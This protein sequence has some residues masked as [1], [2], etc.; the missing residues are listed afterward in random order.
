M[1]PRPRLVALVS[2]IASASAVA[3]P[4]ITL[5]P[6]NATFVVSQN[7]TLSVGATG[8]VAP[9]TFQW[10]RN[11]FNLSGATNA[12]L[13]IPAAQQSD[14]DNYDVVVSDGSSVTSNAVRLTIAPNSYPG[15]LK[16]D[17]S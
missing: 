10:R 15:L 12:T 5:Q 11:G 3:A 1:M 17:P 2:L 14:T 8:S 4:T 7:A 6:V 13:S 9:P 16:F